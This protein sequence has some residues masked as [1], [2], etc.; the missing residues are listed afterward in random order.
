MPRAE[1]KGNSLEEVHQAVELWK[2]D[3]PAVTITKEYPPVEFL[4]GGQHFLSR[5]EGPGELIGAMI[6]VDYEDKARQY[7]GS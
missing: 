7:S 4:F 2:R 3:H 1:F 5:N 6:V